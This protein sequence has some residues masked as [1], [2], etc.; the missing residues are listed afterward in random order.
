MPPSCNSPAAISL[1]ST[2]PRANRVGLPPLGSKT[3]ACSRLLSLRMQEVLW[4]HCNGDGTQWKMA[5][6]S[7]SSIRIFAILVTVFLFAGQPAHAQS[8]ETT[9]SAPPNRSYMLLRE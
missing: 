2:H 1:R 7:V 6:E 8:N 4:R 9:G 5:R 3:L